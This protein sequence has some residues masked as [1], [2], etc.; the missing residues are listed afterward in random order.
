MYLNSTFLVANTRFS[1][2]T[3]NK[4]NKLTFISEPLDDGL[5]EQLEVGKV[6]PSWD[7]KKVRCFHFEMRSCQ[8]KLCLYRLLTSP[9]SAD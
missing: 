5:A 9:F 7:N 8:S 6:N 2:Q 4:R 3:A 1:L